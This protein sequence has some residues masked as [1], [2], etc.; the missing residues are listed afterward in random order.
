MRRNATIRAM[1]ADRFKLKTHFETR[2]GTVYALVVGKDGPKLKPSTS[3]APARFT[4][5]GQGHM[6]FERTTVGSIMPF[7]AQEL[8]HPAIDKTGLTG[9]YDMTLDWMPTQGAAAAPDGDAAQASDSAAPSL[10]T[11]VQEQ[12]GLKLEAQKGPVERLVIDSSVKPSVDGAEV[13]GHAS[14]VPVAGASSQSPQQAVVPMS[15]MAPD[16]HP[17]F[18]VATVKPAD[19]DESK[20]T[21]RI[22]GHR[23]FIKNK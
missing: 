19:P 3:D 9:K 12:L 15:P 7:F 2:Q 14:M 22:G 5:R 4:M 8:R 10:F 13:P 21:F 1:L 11:A 23:I 16:A 6:S 17:T 20:G 18:E